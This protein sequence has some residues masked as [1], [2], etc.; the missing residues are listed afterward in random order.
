[1]NHYSLKKTEHSTDNERVFK[2]VVTPPFYFTCMCETRRS[3]EL[4]SEVY[5]YTESRKIIYVHDEYLKNVPLFVYN[6]T[7][8]ISLLFSFLLYF[9][10]V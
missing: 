3:G 5:D 8:Q 2:V 4:H 1:M 6:Q 7:N 9:L 10:V